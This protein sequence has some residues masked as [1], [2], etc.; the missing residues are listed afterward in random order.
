[1]VAI[2]GCDGAF[3]FLQRVRTL[4]ETGAAPGLPD[5]AADGAEDLRDRLTSQSGVRVLDLVFDSARAGEDGERFRGLAEPL[6]PRGADDES[7]GKEI[8][9][10]AVGAGAD[11]R[12]VELEPLA[13]DLAGGIGI[14]GREGLG[15][16]R[17]DLV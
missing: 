4:S 3:P 12:L 8:V 10:A 2:E 14:A 6:L 16:H 7:R 5:Q 17:H 9:V 13:R 1:P 11:Q 15:D